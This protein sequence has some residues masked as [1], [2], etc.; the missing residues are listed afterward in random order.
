MTTRDDSAAPL[1]RRVGRHPTLEECETAGIGRTYVPTKGYSEGGL[2]NDADE[3]A[4]FEAYMRGHC[5]DVGEYEE[6]L[7]CYDTVE[8]RRLYGVWRDRGSLP[9]V[10]PNVE[11]RGSGVTGQSA[12][13]SPLSPAPQGSASGVRRSNEQI[14][15]SVHR[16]GEPEGDLD[17]CTCGVGDWAADEIVRLRRSIEVLR[18]AHERANEE[19]MSR[20][21][22]REYFDMPIMTNSE[23][24]EHICR[25][26]PSMPDWVQKAALHA[27]STHVGPLEDGITIRDALE[28]MDDD[29]LDE[30]YSDCDQNGDLV[31][32]ETSNVK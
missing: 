26:F 2:P 27:V 11:V 22:T 5:W 16:F 1:E 31:A 24:I 14:R 28:K 21:I 8:V 13:A 3:R 18:Q 30:F 29:A 9:T 17:G 7:D 10:W 12:A 32:M 19:C 23:Q 6:Y 4:R 20:D 15:K 25:S